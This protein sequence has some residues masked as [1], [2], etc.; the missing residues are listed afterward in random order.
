[1]RNLVFTLQFPPR[2]GGVETMAYEL[3]KHMS[4]AGTEISVLTSTEIGGPEFDAQ[5]A[6]P[7][8][9]IPIGVSDTPF[10][11]IWQKVKLL[12]AVNRVLREVNPDCI[13]CLHWDPCA[14]LA[15]FAG[16][17][18]AP[19]RPY[20]LVAHGMELM[21][22]PRGPWARRA[23]EKVR[24]YALGGAREVFAVSRYTRER[25][26]ALEI[27]AARVTVIPNGVA[28]RRAEQP[29]DHTRSAESPRILLT[30]SRLVPRKGHDTVLRALPHVLR[31]VPDVT[32]RIV[33]EGPERERLE[34]LA[35]ELQV[36]KRVE[37]F[38][39]VTEIEKEQLLQDCDLFVLPCSETETDFEG[40][41]I[42]LLE[43]MSHRKPVIAGRSGGV[44]DVVIDGET[45]WLVDPAN[46][47]E[48][49]QL[50]IYLFHN[51]REACQVGLNAF[52]RVR[53]QFNWETISRRYLTAMTAGVA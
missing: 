50:I 15:R 37:F 12:R 49:A 29:S 23:K 10:Q 53:D 3:S 36:E 20:Y 51:K 9:R 6:F 24:A 34:N 1:M 43:A 26:I 31:Q 39:K 22:L 40:F 45:G 7:I 8:Y 16:T 19:R 28:L 44:P 11:Q 48:L 14:Y 46:V 41:G 2:V 42:A 5:Q 52:E 35:R 47:G 32:Y 38:G 17:W 33:G 30:L 18:L 13:L 27:P 21:Q 25:A 4:Q